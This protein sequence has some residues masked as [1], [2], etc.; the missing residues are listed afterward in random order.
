MPSAGDYDGDGVTDL[1]VYRPSNGTT[2]TSAPGHGCYRYTPRGLAGDIPV[3]GDYDERRQDRS[4]R[5]PSFK[6]HLV[7]PCSSSS[8]IATPYSRRCRATSPPGDYDGDGLTDRAIFRP[9]AGVISPSSTG[10]WKWSSGAFPATS[11]SEPALILQ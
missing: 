8:A 11:W 5:V 4:R 10:V 9:S 2:S 1:A 6:W 7:P 3:P